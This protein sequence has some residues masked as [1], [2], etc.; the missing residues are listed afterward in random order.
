MENPQD[1][2]MGCIS[3]MKAVHIPVREDRVIKIEYESLDCMGMCECECKGDGYLFSIKIKKE[4]S[5]E[6]VNIMELKEVII[7][8][9]IHTCKGCLSHGKTWRKYAKILNDKYGYSLLEEKDEDAIFHKEL[10]VIHKVICPVCG[11]FYN[12]RNKEIWINAENSG[13]FICSF[14]GADYETVF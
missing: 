3:K 13:G 9:L 5:N 12:C 6:S 2:F 14:C 7:H 1:L 8:E 11:A 10:P 4:L